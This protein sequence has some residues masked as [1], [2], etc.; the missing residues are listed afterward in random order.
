MELYDANRQWSARPDDQRVKTISELYRRAK[1]F[2][3]EA[4][5]RAN[6]A[7]STLRAEAVGGALCLVGK[8]G[9]PAGLTH[10]VTGQ[11]CDYAGAPAGYIRQLPATLAAQN[12]NHGLAKRAAKDDNAN[13][14]LHV[15]DGDM[16][17]VVIHA[18]NSEKYARFWN[19]EVA[20]RLLNFEVK[21]WKPATPTFN[22]GLGDGKG[23]D[24][25]CYVS[26]HD[27]FAFISHPDRVVKEQGNAKGLLRG[28]IAVNSEVGDKRLALKRFLFREM[29]GNHIIWGA[30]E[31]I[32]V[33]AIHRGKIR[34]RVQAWE[35]EAA[36]YLDSTTGEDEDKIR[37]AQS[38]KIAAT[39]DE[40]LDTLF[41][42]RSLLLSR[43][44]LEAAY[45]A[46]VPDEDGDPRTVWGFVQGLTRSSQA[47]PYGDER[48]RLDTAAGKILDMF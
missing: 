17:K 30:E 45:D 31:V 42:K 6:V 7:V 38:V 43:K 12:I 1:K 46:N 36:R 24:G 41:G 23:S 9:T 20:E 48:M 19:W 10:Y 32:E 22:Q 16:T 33:S 40:V 15:P 25:A 34:E 8:G 28:L 2:A 3:S 4:Y 37:Q 39:K 44:A 13:L 47:T 27:M 35:L 29:C 18:V 5:E 26:D 21:G 14:L 11:V